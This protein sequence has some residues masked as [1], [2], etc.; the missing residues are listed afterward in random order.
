MTAKQY[1]R[2]IYLIS[3]RIKRLSEQRE[4]IRAEMFS[5]KSVSGEM[6]PDKV[7]SS[8]EGDSMLRLIARVDE[9]ERE[10]VKEMERLQKK[11]AR[12]SKKIETL[13]EDKYREVLH[14]RYIMCRKWEDIAEQMN[15]SVRYV[16]MLHGQA[17]QSF[18]KI[19]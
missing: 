18:Q 9:I 1:L 14:Q 11:R 6:N 2:Q 3:A 10:I 13:P 16:Y 17:L 12:M 7:L 8:I 4:Q 19:I 5:I 15:V